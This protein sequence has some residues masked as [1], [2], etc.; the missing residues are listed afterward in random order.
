METNS[1]EWFNKGEW[2]KGL[3]VV[4]D[5]SVNK[6]EL[7]AQFHKNKNLWNKAFPDFRL[8]KN[9]GEPTRLINRGG[10][11]QQRKRHRFL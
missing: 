11:I 3:T 9:G 8:R 10:S 1:S 5:E 4:P 7:F 2:R 6:A